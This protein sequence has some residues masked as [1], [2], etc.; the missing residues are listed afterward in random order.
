M[1]ILKS[2][3]LILAIWGFLSGSGIQCWAIPNLQIFIPG[4]EYDF[5][6]E[7]WVIYSLDYQLWVIGA[8]KDVEEVKF[9]AAV[10]KDEYGSIQV[11]WLQPSSPDYGEG[12][13]SPFSLIFQDPDLVPNDPNRLAYDDYRDEYANGQEPDPRTYGFNSNGTPQMG[14]GR[15]LPPHGVFPTDFYEYFIG[16]FGTGETIQNYIPGEEEGDTALGEIR[17]FGIFVSGYT[18]VDIV[19]YDHVIL[20]KNKAKYVFS[21]FSHDGASTIPEPTTM[22]LLGSGLI[23]LAGFR[24]KFRKTLISRI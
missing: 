20:G 12:G 2:F 9:A 17:K 11:T 21:P 23:G 8:H 3:I 13:P 16:D 7:T 10:P 18:W 22:L 14:D 4:A 1:K 19:A 6:T 5:E 24:R 15:L